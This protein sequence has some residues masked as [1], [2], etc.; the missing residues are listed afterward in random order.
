[1]IVYVYYIYIYMYVVC[2]SAVPKTPI[3][4]RSVIPLYLRQPNHNDHAIIVMIHTTIVMVM[5]VPKGDHGIII[6]SHTSMVMIS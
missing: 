4:Y 1:M 3:K 5:V 6:L 2:V